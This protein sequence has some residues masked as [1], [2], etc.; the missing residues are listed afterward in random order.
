MGDPPLAGQAPQN[1]QVLQGPLLHHP[2][3]RGRGFLE[4]HPHTAC[5]QGWLDGRGPRR[6]S[7]VS[8]STDWS[9]KPQNRYGIKHVETY[10]CSPS[11]EC[12]LLPLKLHG[13]P[14]GSP[15]LEARPGLGPGH[16]LAPGGLCPLSP[17]L[18][19]PP[20]CPKEQGG[21]GGGLSL[22]TRSRAQ[23][24]EQ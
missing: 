22:V 20:I 17:P 6:C 3:P 11:L 18:H 10:D 5:A 12:P 15:S 14:D 13:S 8:N 19:K 1:P 21:P 7:T 24:T 23:S 9:Y 2:P 16:Q 4:P